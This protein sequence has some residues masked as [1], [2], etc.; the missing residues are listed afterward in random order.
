MRFTPP[1]STMA[2]NTRQT[3]QCAGDFAGLGDVADTEGSQ[4]TQDSEDHSQPLPALAQA[5]FNIVHGA[6]LVDALLI[7]DTV[8]HRQGDLAVLGAHA[9]ECRHPHPEGS[10][11]AAHEDGAGDAGDV[12]GTHSAGQSG[13]HRLEGTEVLAMVLSLLSKERANC[14]L[15]DVTKPAHLD[16]ASAEGQEDASTHQ[17]RQH[18]RPPYKAVYYAIDFFDRFD[19]CSHPLYPCT[20]TTAYPKNTQG[21]QPKGRTPK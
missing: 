13:G 20:Q 19:H 11:G 2:T 10:A 7:S 16:P 3:L 12:A 4:T 17:Q 18:D 21:A 1:R 9:K 8:L 14:V 15:H 6:A 5:V